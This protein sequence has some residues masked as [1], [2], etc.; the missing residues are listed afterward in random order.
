MLL[1]LRIS[2][3][4]LKTTGFQEEVVLQVGRAAFFR[5]IFLREYSIVDCT[6]YKVSAEEIGAMQE[7]VLQVGAHRS[8]APVFALKRKPPRNI[9]VPAII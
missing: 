3:A 1:Q 9:V 2:K 8:L 4:A 7:V 5:C 6:R